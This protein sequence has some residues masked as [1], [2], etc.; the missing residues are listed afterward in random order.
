M[1]DHRRAAPDEPREGRYFAACQP[2]L[3]A[4][5]VLETSVHFSLNRRKFSW[6]SLLVHGTM[7]THELVR[8]RQKHYTFRG[9]TYVEIWTRSTG[10]EA[11]TNFHR[12]ISLV[13]LIVLVAFDFGPFEAAAGQTGR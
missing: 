11:R 13:S 4:A 1:C 9:L 3:L 8:D 7:G 2:H 5:D 6:R 10:E 12:A